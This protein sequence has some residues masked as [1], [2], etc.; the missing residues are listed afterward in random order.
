[1][2]LMMPGTSRRLILCRFFGWYYQVVEQFFGGGADF[3]DGFLEGGF[4]GARRP[5][6]ARHLAHKLPRCRFNFVIGGGCFGIS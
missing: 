5:S 2:T 6:V 3:G 4:V 1:M